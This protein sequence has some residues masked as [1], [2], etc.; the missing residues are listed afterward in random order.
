MGLFVNIIYNIIYSWISSIIS[1]VFS[2]IILQKS[3]YYADL[4]LKKHLI[5]LLVVSTYKINENIM[6]YLDFL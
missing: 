1:P 5:F 4:L 2:R 3:F 6:V